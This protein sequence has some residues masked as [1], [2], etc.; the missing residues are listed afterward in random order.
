VQRR[1]RAPVRSRPATQRIK[2]AGT[3]C[4]PD[5]RAGTAGLARGNGWRPVS[6]RHV[7]RRAGPGRCS[8]GTRPA[9]P[10]RRLAGLSCCIAGLGSRTARLPA[11]IT[12]LRRLNAGLPASIAGLGRLNAGMGARITRLGRLN[13]GMGARIAGLG[14][15]V[16]GLSR[17]ISGG[18][19]EAV[20]LATGNAATL[21]TGSARHPR[22]QS[23]RQHGAWR[24][25][26]QPARADRPAGRSVRGGRTSAGTGHVAAR[27]AC[28]PSRRRLTS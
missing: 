22:G 27:S 13:A 25:Q 11:R 7:T 5:R 24:A 9:A 20:E 14:R 18:S 15:R 3:T 4:G 10:D 12:G 23:A 21:A 2:R 28:R 19:T 6:G 17:A 26:W 1:R 8:G 16:A